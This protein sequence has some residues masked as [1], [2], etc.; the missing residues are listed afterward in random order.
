MTVRISGN[1]ECTGLT[2]Q[3]GPEKGQ[4]TMAHEP[5]F[6]FPAGKEVLARE[7]LYRM[8]RNKVTADYVRNRY[9]TD[10][11]SALHSWA[12]RPEAMKNKG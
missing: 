7:D 1:P 2:L 9:Q 3:K 11:L 8:H 5:A 10:D 6:P 12:Y 4:C